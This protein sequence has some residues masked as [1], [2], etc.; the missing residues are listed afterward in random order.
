MAAVVRRGVRLKPW[1]SVEGYSLRGRRI[2]A[3]RTSAGE[4]P[5][6]LVIMAA[7]AWSGPLLQSIGIRV[8]TP[9]LKGQIVLLRGE[10]PLIRRIVEHGKNYLVPRDDGRVLVGA[11]EHDAGFD[12]RPTFADTRS[13]LDEA[14]R[15]CP[16]L[17]QAEVEATWAGLR[18]GSVDTK[19]TIG[20]APGFDN[21]II[22]TGHKRAGLQLAPATGELVADLILG[23][24]PRL[25]LDPFRPDRQPGS[26]GEDAFRS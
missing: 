19:P 17:S 1:H 23:R 25:D 24:P 7:G 8:P 12:T 6:D 14:L 3:I 10:P 13:L 15:L 2:E 21:L 16:I 11:T 4:I 9:P 18:P 26:A 20:A 5:C 22:A